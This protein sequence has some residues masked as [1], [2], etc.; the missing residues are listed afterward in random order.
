MT[1]TIKDPLW[2]EWADKFLAAGQDRSKVEPMD[3][4]L[5]LLMMN[6]VFMET[7]DQADMPEDVKAGLAQAFLYQVFKKRAESLGLN[8]T[9]PMSV[10]LSMGVS[11]G[12]GTV[13][14]YAHALRRL[15]DVKGYTI[16]LGTLELASAFPAGF[17]TKATLHEL[18]D[19]QKHLG[20]CPDNFLDTVAA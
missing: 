6:T 17:L 4:Q 15:Q 8:V 9:L 10:F 11:R 19:G 16:P 18:W 20:G 13:V 1:T 3:K 2:V 14:M 7:A 12:P 5:S